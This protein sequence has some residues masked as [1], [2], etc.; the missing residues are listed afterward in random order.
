MKI[1]AP[2]G[3]VLVALS[4]ATGC[5][6]S[7]APASSHE[8]SGRESS[9]RESSAASPASPPAADVGGAAKDGVAAG[10]PRD[11]QRALIVTGEISVT[12]KNVASAA[13]RLRAEVARAGGYVSDAQETGSDRYRQSTLELRVPV[14]KTAS[15]RAALADLGEIT[16]NAEKVV[17]VT[18]ARSDLKARLR[19]ARIEERRIEEIM[20][21]HTAALSD[22]LTAEREVARVR[23][24][25]EQLEAQERSMDGRIALAT[26]KVHLNG[27]LVP[28]T[29]QPAAWETPG[30]S[31]ASAF[32]S[33]LKGT[34]AALVYLA[35]GLA[36]S[37]PALVPIGLVLGAVVVAARRRRKALGV[38]W[39]QS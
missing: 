31:I 27:E 35:M 32:R 21:S 4:L 2:L 3:L 33:G 25:I 23:E 9:G 36:A 20:Q 16:S 29:T 11:A 12:T 38:A 34:A 15:L 5:A 1:S 30:K 22:V 26:I 6:N 10:Q 39:G 18:D 14:D 17:D 8:S 7:S 28:Q 24:K 19:N 37:S 13:E